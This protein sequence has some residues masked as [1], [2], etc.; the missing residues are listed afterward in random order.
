MFSLAFCAQVIVW[1]VFGGIGTL[2]GPVIACFIIQIVSNQLGQTGIGNPQI[3]LGVLFVGSVLLLPN[4][5][6]PTITSWIGKL[7]RNNPV[8]RAVLKG[9]GQ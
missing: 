9:E 2:I 7:R 1:V 5:L 3:I 4:G 6:V 8:S